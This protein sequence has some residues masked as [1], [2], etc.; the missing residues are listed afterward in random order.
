MLRHGMLVCSLALLLVV[1]GRVWAEEN[2][3]TKSLEGTW[4][5][6][7]AEEN[8]EAKE[9]YKDAVVTFHEGTF[10]V[11]LADGDSHDGT[12]KVMPA[13]G[14]PAAIDL[15]ASGGPNKGKT[16]QG[17]FVIEGDTLKICRGTSADKDRPTE[18]SGKADSG[19]VLFMLKRE[20]P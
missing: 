20:K 10:T 15:S 16:F 12:Y 5:V 3:G 14:G 19:M 9:A 11:K 2:K 18:F 13:A 17:I 6:A 7:S 8:G 4:K 1:A